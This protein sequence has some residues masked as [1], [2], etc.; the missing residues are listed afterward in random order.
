MNLRQLAKHLDKQA[1]MFAR[2]GEVKKTFASMEVAAFIRRK[3][4]EFQKI[5]FSLDNVDNNK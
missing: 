3:P 2:N 4:K 1:I 5:K